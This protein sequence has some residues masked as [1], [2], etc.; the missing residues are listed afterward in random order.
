MLE[1]I[2][3]KIYDNYSVILSQ[4]EIDCLKAEINSL[5]EQLKIEQDE[6]QTQDMDYYLLLKCI[7]ATRDEEYI[8]KCI[9][10]NVFE[11]EDYQHQELILATQDESLIKEKILSKETSKDLK[12]WLLKNWGIQTKD[13]IEYV[14]FLEKALKSEDINFSSEYKE[15]LITSLKENPNIKETGYINLIRRWIKDSSFQLTSSSKT[16]ILLTLK[17]LEF[18]QQPSKKTEPH[19]IVGFSIYEVDIIN[20]MHAQKIIRFRRK[21]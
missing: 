8:K 9:G 5:I 10:E 21:R 18:M 2:F 6:A 20:Y 15:N 13:I 3:D 1:E 14:T 12:Y 16:N 11:F 7:L 4:E 19:E 17:D